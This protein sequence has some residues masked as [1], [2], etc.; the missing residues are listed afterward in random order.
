VPILEVHPAPEQTAVLVPDVNPLVYTY[1]LAFYFALM[2]AAR[3]AWWKILVGAAALLPFQAWGIAFDFLS[4]IGARLGP[5]VAAL[6]GLSGWRLEGV[7][8]GYQVGSLIF[9]SLIPVL[10]WAAFNRR[11]IEVL[12]PFKTMKPAFASTRINVR[13]RTDVEHDSP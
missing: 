3:A 6:S 9:P 8:L 1:G 12:M 7:A 5:E 13:Q 10:L 2:L 4:Q 11:M